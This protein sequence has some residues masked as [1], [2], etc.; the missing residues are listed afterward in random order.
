MLIRQPIGRSMSVTRQ[1]SAMVPKITLGYPRE[2]IPFIDNYATCLTS[3]VLHSTATSKCSFEI[4][5]KVRLL[6]TAVK[7]TFFLYIHVFFVWVTNV[8]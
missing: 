3:D 7:K 4:G 6:E 8:I 5:D 2:I 1:C